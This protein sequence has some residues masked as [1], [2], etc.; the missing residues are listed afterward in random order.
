MKLFLSLFICASLAAQLQSGPMLG[1]SEMREVLIWVQ[2]KEAARVEISYWPKGEKNQK[3]KTDPVQTTKRNFFAARLVADAV[4]HSKTYEYSV[5]INGEAV[6]LPYKTEFQTQK[7]FQWQEPR[8]IHPPEFTF[9]MGSC[10][11]VNETDVDRAGK[12]YGRNY[13]IFDH[14]H[15][16]K[17]D[18]MLWLGDNTYL[19]EVDWFS[20]TGMGRRYTHTRSL[21]ELQPLLASTHHYATWDDH[22]YGPNDADRSFI[23]KN[24]ALE[25]FNLFW[26]NQTAGL[27]EGDGVY[28]Q[29]QWGDVDFFLTDNRWFRAPNNRSGKADAPYLG[30][31]QLNWL[32]DALSASSAPFKVVAF[33]TQAINPT[34]MYELYANY[35][36][37]RRQLLAAIAENKVEGVVF[38][39]GDIHHSEVNVLE[40]EGAYPIF[41]LTSSSL[42]A[43]IYSRTADENIPTLVRESVV[44]E[45]NFALITVS[46]KRN[47]RSLWL[48]YINAK[49]EEKYELRIHEND[50]K[51]TKEKK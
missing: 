19:R 44:N 22:D 38:V 28:S 16:R 3:Q 5:L 6:A 48:R 29:F 45:N 49:G 23:H 47:D 26:G 42:T 24:T 18:F 4:E 40:R 12:P 50:L 39:S 13:Q 11:F 31:K 21:P 43:G 1:Y 20:R 46:G 8:G 32:I 30:E 34:Q 14:I 41:D 37:E 35:A 2:T 17:P 15:Q 27:A 10:F 33:G 7:L 51:Y 25:M 9:A 36:A